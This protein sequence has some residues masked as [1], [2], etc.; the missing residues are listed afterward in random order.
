M[1]TGIVTGSLWATKKSPDLRGQSLLRVAM[2]PQELVAAD[3]VGA[4]EGDRVIVAFGGAAR[5]LCDGLPIDAAIVAILDETE[6]K[7][8]EC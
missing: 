7:I 2:G 5:K 6:E 8:R 3:L 4:G 1:K